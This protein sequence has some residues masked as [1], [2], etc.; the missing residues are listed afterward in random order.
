MDFLG[1]LDKQTV[2]RL[3]SG[4]C[5]VFDATNQRWFAVA[6]SIR[7]DARRVLYRRALQIASRLSWQLD[8]TGVEALL[9]IELE[10]LIA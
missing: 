6:G 3:T 1:S 10:K 8:E 9:S 5:L 7:L 4:Q 2:F